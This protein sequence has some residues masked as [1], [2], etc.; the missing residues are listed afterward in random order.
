MRFLVLGAGAI[1]S[2]FGGFLAKAGHSVTLIGRKAHMDAIAR[3]GLVIDGIWGRH[4]ITQGI[5]PATELTE[6]LREALP[7]FDLCLLT[8]KSYD[9]AEAVRM[10]HNSFDDPPTVLSLQNGLGNLE[11]I[12]ERIEAHKTIGGRVIFGV[13]HRQA[14]K[15]TVTVSADVTRIGAYKNVIPWQ[16]VAYLSTVFQQAGLP[17]E[18]TDDIERFVWGKVLYNCALNALATLL[19]VNYGMLLASEAT[20]D[21]MREIVA[22]IFTVAQHLSVRLDWENPQQYLSILFNELI[23]KT[24]D[25]HP[26]ML[27]DVLNGKRTEIDALNGAIAELG[28]QHGCAVP[29]N[30]MLRNLIK[31]TENLCRVKKHPI[32]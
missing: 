1:G 31:A 17:T 25:H 26:S 24:F 32:T 22:E 3:D 4:L 16:E 2:V 12:A 19:N 5:T 9:T 13:E 10:L 11:I 18:P 8:V 30:S 21:I 28:K 23:P 27:Q 14:G 7:P 29:Y 15:V 6:T 20:K